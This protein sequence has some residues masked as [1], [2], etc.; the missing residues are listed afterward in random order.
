MPLRHCPS[1]RCGRRRTARC[2]GL[3]L[4]R[5]R[6]RSSR[7]TACGC[8]PGG[9]T[10]GRPDERERGRGRQKTCCA[11]TAFRRRQTGRTRH[12]A[13]RPAQ[14]CRRAPGR[15]AARQRRVGIL[16]LLDVS[17]RGRSGQRHRVG[18]GRVVLAHRL[19][20]GEAQQGRAIV[21]LRQQAVRPIIL[22]FRQQGEP[23]AESEPVGR[24]VQTQ[25]VGRAVADRV[26]VVRRGP[27]ADFLRRKSGGGNADLGIARKNAGLQRSSRESACIDDTDSSVT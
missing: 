11:A 6:E 5:G 8:R 21:D 20:I 4:A 15:L 10:A 12:C 23:V 3:D 16:I 14:S 26:A 25:E 24:I 2:S 22:R 9:R 7:G 17:C 13:G 19:A 27:Q 18:P 1:V